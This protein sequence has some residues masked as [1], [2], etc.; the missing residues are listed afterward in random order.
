M[1]I[2]LFK[3]FIDLKKAKDPEFS[4]LLK[5]RASEPKEKVK[6]PKGSRIGRKTEKE[7]DQEMLDNEENEDNN[8]SSFVF[9]ESPACNVLRVDRIG[10]D[11][12]L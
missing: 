7:E 3:H 8:D 6:G 10:N 11:I 9:T 5:E 2:E 1:T 4:K 12:T